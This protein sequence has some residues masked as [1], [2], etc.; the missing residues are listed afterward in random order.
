M[1]SVH[2]TTM[3]AECIRR[4][5]NLGFKYAHHGTPCTVGH[6]CFPASEP[7]PREQWSITCEPHDSVAGSA[8]DARALHG[9]LPS[10]A[11]LKPS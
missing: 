2:N 6:L 11:G 3:T 9:V 7:V 4:A 8:Y 1:A 5:P 10:R